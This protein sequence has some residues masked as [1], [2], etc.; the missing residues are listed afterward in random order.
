MRPRSSH[1]DSAAHQLRMIAN[2]PV[3]WAWAVLWFAVQCVLWIA[4]GATEASSWLESLALSRDG[5]ARGSWWQLFTHGLV[6]GSWLHL[7]AN[8]V[9]LVLVGSRIEHIVGSRTV[10]RTIAAGIIGGG[11]LHLLLGTGLLVGASGG[12]FALL[13]LHTTLSPQSRFWPLPVSARHL[14]T[15]LLAAALILAL[16]NPQL[17][18]P[19]A[20]ALGRWLADHGFDSWFRLGHACHFGGGLVGW[21]AGRWMLRPRVSLAALRR[22]RARREGGR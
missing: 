2:A 4:G 11:A 3:T 6:H 7:L 8:T 1:L 19:G 5:I 21:V 14:G 22:D 18:L 13:L 20:A 12:C 17:G 16:V 9:F 10:T 15:G